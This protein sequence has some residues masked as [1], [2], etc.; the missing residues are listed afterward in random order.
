MSNKWTPEPWKKS[1]EPYLTSD[2]RY[3]IHQNETGN[4]PHAGIR[5]CFRKESDRDRSIT[6]VNAL[7][8]LNPEHVK[9]LIGV[10]EEV[11][12]ERDNGFV[13]GETDILT[14]FEKIDSLAESLSKI[15]LKEK[16]S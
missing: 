7:Q 11:C 3:S 10:A 12:K 2:F 14:L 8:G 9:E 1:N 4:K 13:Y 16:E 5:A 15:K 6:C